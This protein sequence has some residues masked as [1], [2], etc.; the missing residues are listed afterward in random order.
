MKSA[1]TSLA[2]LI[3]GDSALWRALWVVVWSVGCW[4]LIIT[5]AADVG[6]AQPAGGT[7]RATGHSDSS[8][9]K[10]RRGRPIEAQHKPVSVTRQYALPLEESLV[11][12]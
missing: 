1:G 3:M 6:R 12:S 7:A 5:I 10:G 2:Q 4:F 9:S 11:K 8:D